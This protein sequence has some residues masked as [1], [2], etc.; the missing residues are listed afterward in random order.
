MS[1][2][3]L[4]GQCEISWDLMGPILHYGDSGESGTLSTMHDL[5]ILCNYK[6]SKHFLK[7]MPH[8]QNAHNQV[9]LNVIQQ[10]ILI[11]SSFTTHQTVLKSINQGQKK[12]ASK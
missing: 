3:D 1:K 9:L 10:K 4:M 8:S 7:L 2:C 11:F 12:A 6:G 5:R